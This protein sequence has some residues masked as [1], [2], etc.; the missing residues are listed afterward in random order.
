MTPLDSLNISHD[1]LT[2]FYIIDRFPYISSS[3]YDPQNNFS[4]ISSTKFRGESSS[5]LYAP[6]FINGVT[7]NNKEKAIVYIIFSNL[8]F[9][10]FFD[11]KL[12]CFL[13]SF[14]RAQNSYILGA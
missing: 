3:S 1:I 10:T 11:F 2:C 7:N 8:L 14:Q 5:F 9:S 12:K 13:Y 4:E 6:T